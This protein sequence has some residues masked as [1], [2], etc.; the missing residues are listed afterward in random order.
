M[1]AIL[2]FRQGSKTSFISSGPYISEPFFDTD[3]NIIHIGVSGSSTITLTK[4][5]DINSGSFSVSGDISGSNLYLSGDITAS[6]TLL[7]GDITIGGNI[8]LGD[9]VQDNITILGQFDSD[10]IP[11]ASATYNLGSQT[12]KWNHLYALSASIDSIDLISN[13]PSGVISGSDQLPQ[14]TISSSQQVIEFLP[15][16]VISGSAVFT[17]GNNLVSIGAS[18]Q[19]VSNLGFGTQLSIA[20]TGISG[21][22]SFDDS[23][24]SKSFDY[25]S[26]NVR[27]IDTSTGVS[28]AIKPDSSANKAW[29]FDTDG[30][31]ISN[32]GGWSSGSVYANNLIASSS[33]TA[34]NILVDNDIIANNFIGNIQST[35]GV[36]SG[37]Q[38]VISSLPSGTVSS[39]QQTID[40]LPAGLISGSAIYTNG[41]DFVTIGSDPLFVQNL[42]AGN[43]LSLSD[44]ADSGILTYDISGSA[45][46]Y[47]YVSNDVRYIDTNVGV[48][49][50]I[51]TNSSAGQ[52]WVFDT[53]GNLLS[54]GGGWTSGAIYT[55]DLIVSSSITASY[56]V[57]DNDITANNF[58]GN[59]QATNGV[60]S[61][62]SQLTSSFV[63]LSSNQTISGTKT[64][65][66]IVVDGTGSFANNVTIYGN[67]SVFGT[68]SILNSENLSIADNMIYLNSGSTVTN[69]DLGWA[70]NYNDGTY[71]HAG[72][73]R[74]AADG[75]F[76][77][78]DG[79]VPEPEGNIDTSH[80]SFNF[81]DIQFGEGQATLV[82]AE[83]FIGTGSQLVFPGTDIV[84]SSQQVIDFLPNGTVSGSTQI[85]NGSG[86]VSSSNQI[87]T[88]S[89][90]FQQGVELYS[91]NGVNPLSGLYGSAGGLGVQIR[92]LSADGLSFDG[93]GNLIIDTGSDY[94]VS[95]AQEAS[96]LGLPQGT[97]S[98]SSQV[99]ELLPLNTV[100]GSD[101]VTQ[102]LDTR[103]LEIN[104]DNVLSSSNEN[105][106]DFSQSVDLRLLDTLSSGSETSQSLHTL[107][108][109]F[110]TSGS[111]GTSAFYNVSSS[112]S[113]D[114][115]VIPNVKAVYDYINNT[116]GA[117][118][119]TGVSASLGLFGGGDSGYVSLSLDTAS[120][121]FQEGVELYSSTLPVGVISGSSQIADY[122]LTDN[123][124]LNLGTG[125][126]SGSNLKLTG[127]AVIDGDI[128]LAGNITIGDA[129]SDTI[130]FAGDISSSLIPDVTNAFDLG[131]TTRKF[132]NVYATN[133]YGTINS[134]N[135]VVSGSQ[136]IV[137]SLPSGVVSG[138]QQIVDS[139][140]SGVVS[141]SQQIV[142][143]IPSGVVSGSKQITDF[144]FISESNSLYNDQNNLAIGTN[145]PTNL[146]ATQF[147]INDS[148]TA[149]TSGLISFTDSDVVKSYDYVNSNYRYI[150]TNT[151]VGIVLKPD[152]DSTKAWVIDTDGDLVSNGGSW[153]SGNAYMNNLI[154]SSSVTASY[155]LVDN[156]ITANN[157]I[158]NIQ[159]TNG[160]ISGSSQLTGSFVDL[161]SVQ[162]IGGT[163]TFNDIVV[164]GTGSFAYIE[165][166]AGS[167]KIIGD[168]FIILNNDTPTERYAGIAVYDSGSVGVTSSLQFDG[169]TN[170]WFYEYSDDGG[171]TTDH[172][173]VLFG[174]EYSTKGA[175][176]YP[177]NNTIQKGNG[178]HH[179][180]DSN[181]SDDGTT[182][183]L[184]SDTTVN[185]VLSAT[186]FAG[187]ISGSS[188]VN[189]NTITNFD[190]NV[191]DKL[192]A[193][194][195]ISGSSQVSIGASQVTEISNLTADEGA[196]LENIGTTTIS[197]TQWGYLGG[198]NQELTTTSDVD[199]SGVDIRDAG[200][201]LILRDTDTSVIQNQVLGQIKFLHSDSDGGFSEVGII[202]SVATENF[203]GVTS[204]SYKIHIDSNTIV[205]GTLESTGDIVAYASS[206][207]RLKDEII[208]ISNPIEKISQI[209]GYS[210][211][212]NT[213]KQH[214]YK[215][216][217][218][219]V[220]AQEIEEILPELVD[221]R[222][223][224]YKAV[225]Y[226]RLV[227]LLIEGIKE[228]SEE[229]KEL[230]EKI[231]NRE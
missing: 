206:D 159:A 87:D 178:G 197:S 175:P 203:V 70:G 134:T 68:E 153:A 189:A 64:F 11:S 45:K 200:P 121:H 163:K 73:F 28:I 66:D 10:L 188:Q 177:T 226:D 17:N 218:Y 31:L 172:G 5:E 150:D 85:T 94:F 207:R 15:S 51:K 164:N 166:V 140:P 179:L 34:S 174:P 220:I 147:T 27:Y 101:Q 144:G 190:S 135:G 221:T 62:S 39:S 125:D 115:N 69:P 124:T 72:I 36:L 61:G 193:E 183:T 111:L 119:I 13:L 56:M 42:G 97:V 43:Q 44:I 180:L 118:D 212:W 143:S 128:T 4:L 217:D 168:A 195:V 106:S 204:D 33:V 129:S 35:N 25:V 155:M 162:T 86:I 127:N 224:G 40:N 21:I 84:S 93:P 75:I 126:I 77:F 192:N 81:A 12:K 208:P 136:Q 16:G 14:N 130:A 107:V 19:N 160:V 222:E 141:G 6:N 198:L 71:A 88:G 20:G 98:G 205:N 58:I 157:F 209:G 80:V 170:D 146:G 187:M 7:S 149:G 100:S 53:E 194:T 79:Y 151:G 225:K 82:T 154:A 46:S 30:D 52:A 201:T 133:L 229:V 22:L 59:I 103:Y 117:A 165:S 214:I 216:K 3:T 169:Q 152:A 37:S 123:I 57:V 67:L 24:F 2:Q 89:T 112:L 38:Q 41:S 96:L 110:P 32:G 113:D 158:G 167:A 60:I 95:G 78:Y 47:D 131:S 122:L 186:T 1:A 63:D 48:S 145:T 8:I 182:I 215:G 54:G 219:G 50:A 92:G 55:N 142:D 102:S 196:Q 114:P 231:N 211:I 176:T 109:N 120:V 116:I 90:H 230:K 23:G 104:G 29:V 156:D 210:F 185:G 202:K 49:V 108:G 132:A 191:K 9:Q 213:E 181:I 227:S 223:N 76:K 18:T 138:S 91:I 65:N 26:S 139:I 83:N 74:D 184:N 105:F 173:A 171:V 137:D 228:L 148:N 199:F 99:I 161:S